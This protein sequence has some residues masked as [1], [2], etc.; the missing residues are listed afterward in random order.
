[1]RRASSSSQLSILPACA[2]VAGLLV[3]VGIAGCT[4]SDP[5]A[6][7]REL[8][9]AGDFEGSLEPLRERLAERPDDAEAN[10]LYGRA[11]V[12]TQQPSL[13]E[14]SLRKALE[15]PEWLLPAGLQLALAALTTR[16]YLTAIEATGRVLEVDPDNVDALMTQANAYAH[17]NADHEKALADADRV[18]ELDPDNIEAFEP[19]ILALLGLERIE[20]TGEAMETL[21]ERIEGAELAPS[22]LAWHCATLAIFADESGEPALAHERWGDCL[23]RYPSHPNVVSSALNFYDARGARDRS[24]EIARAALEDAPSSRDYRVLLADRLRLAGEDEAAGAVLRKGTESEHPQH[25]AAGW[26]D[27]AKHYQRVGDHAAAAEAAERALELARGEAGGPHPQLLFEYADML[28]L[29]GQLDRALAAADELAV[30]AQREMIRAR[31][32]QERGEAV[33]ALEHFEEAFR[34]WP[35]NPWGRY[36]AALAAEALG[37]FDRAAEEYR[38]S[39]RINPGATDARN[40]VAR[41]YAAEG[42]PAAALALLRLVTQSAPLDLEGELLSLRL[43]GWVGDAVQLRRS[44]AQFRRSPLLLGRALAHAAQ[45]VRERTGPAAAARLLREAQGV[46]LE[47]PRDADALRALVR[48]S[49]EAEQLEEA[50]VRVR[51][52][53]RAHPEAAALHE[54]GGL[55]LELGGAPADA[56]RAAY[57][58]A[59]ELDPGNARALAGLGRLALDGDP[60]RALSLFDRAAAADPSDP[61]PKRAAARALLA[62]GEARAAEER[63]EA[64]LREHPYESGAAAELAALQLERGVATGRTLER[65]NRAVRFGGGADALDLLSRVHA[66]RNEPERASEAAAR[67]QALRERQPPDA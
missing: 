18:L 1:V 10:Y 16:G 11:L 48:F 5:L 43:W 42:R 3:C 38:Y 51:A 56:V 26:F 36:Y 50:E 6:E 7:V 58:R 22:F 59:L 49:H 4:P 30:P 25:A 62:S 35:D 34:L 55:A 61:E 31:V 64:L 28:L 23:E 44:L 54:I 66:R 53:L 14:W 40:R 13:A 17:S 9:A 65:A 60:E 32:A 46:D 37:D 52:A 19:R 12:G 67:A 29:A 8:Q 39:I 24:L 2:A 27:L 45:G 21:G 47:D 15:D 57:A 41:L 20:E 33:R 63:F